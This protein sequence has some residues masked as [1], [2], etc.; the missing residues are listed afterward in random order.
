[1]LTDVSEVRT[2]TIISAMKEAV[3]TSETSV[4]IYL[5]TWQYIPEDSEELYQQPIVYLLESIKAQLMTLNS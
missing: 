2:A 3:R 5:T 4:N 1:M